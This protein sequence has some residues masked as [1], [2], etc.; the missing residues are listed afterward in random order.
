MDGKTRNF[1]LLDLNS[2]HPSFP[3][4]FITY[5]SKQGINLP[6]DFF[7]TLES[8][9]TKSKHAPSEN[10]T[11]QIFLQAFAKN[12]DSDPLIKEKFVEQLKKFRALQIVPSYD[13]KE[14]ELNL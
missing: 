6:S 5:M 3:E 12:N 2:Y 10:E 4:T 9:L 8:K 13:K 11:I 7:N 1:D 14:L